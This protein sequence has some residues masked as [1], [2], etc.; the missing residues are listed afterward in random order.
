MSPRYSRRKPASVSSQRPSSPR[1]RA[2]RPDS[3]WPRLSKSTAKTKRYHEDRQGL[4]HRME[5]EGGNQVLAGKQA[6]EEQAEHAALRPRRSASG[7]PG[8]GSRSNQPA[9]S[10]TRPWPTVAEH[11][12]EQQGH[13]QREQGGRIRLVRPRDAE[14][15]GKYLERP[16][17]AG[18][19]QDLRAGGFR[20][21]AASAAAGRGSRTAPAPGQGSPRSGRPS[22]R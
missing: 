8:T 18:I 7:R 6:A 1:R 3:N 12:A 17:P 10:S 9:T 15:A 20:A 16:Q 14:G 19:V 4:L 22:S 11:V 13:H 21:A 2:P 5:P